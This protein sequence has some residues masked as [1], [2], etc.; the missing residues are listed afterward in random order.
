MV[1][2]DVSNAQPSAQDADTTMWRLED[3]TVE[4][5]RTAHWLLSAL[6]QD[7]G[8]HGDWKMGCWRSWSLFA[9]SHDTGMTTWRLENEMLE[10]IDR[11]LPYL[12]I[13]A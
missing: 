5:I 7:V 2:V 3:G 10:V 4:V 11:C 9:L 8:G 6:S 12:T 1:S 13:L